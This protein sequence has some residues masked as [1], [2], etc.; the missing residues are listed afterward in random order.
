MKIV[1]KFPD[2]SKMCRQL[3]T[4]PSKIPPTA[5]PNYRLRPSYPPHPPCSP[6]RSDPEADSKPSHQKKISNRQSTRY[7]VSPRQFLLHPIVR[8][9]VH[10]S[11]LVCL[12]SPSSFAEI[13]TDKDGNRVEYTYA[14][15]SDS[16]KIALAVGY[17]KDFDPEDHTK[18]WPAVFEMS[19]YQSATGLVPG[20][21]YYDGLYITVNASLRG[22]GA[23]EGTFGIFSDRSS[24]DGH[25]IIED[26]IVKQ[27]WSNQKVGISGHSWTGLTGWRVAATNP[28]HLSALVVSGLF[29]DARRGLAQIGGIPNVGHPVK[30]TGNFGNTGG[31]FNSD[32]AA[33]ANRKLSEADAQRL[34]AS[35]KPQKPFPRLQSGTAVGARLKTL[36]ELAG[37][38]RAPIFLLHAYQDEQTGPSGA[39]LFDQLPDDIPKRMVISNGHHGMPIR[40]IPRRRAWFDHWVLGRQSDWIGDAANSSSP[41]EAFFEVE[42]RHGKKNAPLVSSDF[43]L[44]ETEWTR[45]YLS[46]ENTLSASPATGPGADTYDVVRDA[47]DAE[48]DRVEYHLSFE[49]PTAIC[50]PIAVTLW[51]DCTV[52]DT[53]LFVVLSDIAPDGRIR[54]LQRGMLQASLRA[55]DEQQSRRVEIDGEQVLVRPWHSLDKPEPLEPG[56]AYRFE[57]EVP[58]VGHVFRDGHQLSLSISRPPA[59][60]PVPYPE[61]QKMAFKTGSFRYESKHPDSTVMVHRS[62]ESPSSILLPL[63][64]EVP[65][66]TE[67][68]PATID[69]M[70]TK[71]E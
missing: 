39:W 18:Q 14:T 68:I 48:I 13:E 6:I 42:N 1:L 40:F 28:P 54:A 47:A 69:R 4:F 30:W 21:E 9:S 64:P 34:K 2:S 24:Q 50:G 23:S 59:S 20:H 51:A 27:P 57:I 7:N 62:Q 19:G 60:D 65:A 29:D 35:R 71:A 25:E 3:E 45:Y 52:A 32:D 43:P 16:V 37:Q 55:I 61:G 56:K 53:D 49:E 17:P 44:P 12:L 5:T 10:L 38:I 26:W 11:I 36:R 33:I 58:P 46:Q 15:M 67:K 8:V 31:V 66:L 70:W 63:L 22:T 41:V